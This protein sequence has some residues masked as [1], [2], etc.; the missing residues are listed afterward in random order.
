MAPDRSPQPP[1][2]LVIED[3]PPIR[4]LV[5]TYLEA[6]GFSVVGVGDGES[7]LEHARELSPDVIVLDLMRQGRS[8]QQGG[9]GI[10]L[11]IARALVQAHSGHVR[12]HSPGPAKGST[13]TVTVPRA[14]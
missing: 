13:F 4:Q 2:V 1:R 8:R 12:A 6:E 11:A 5:A 3:G 10:G 7:G 14:D 9:S